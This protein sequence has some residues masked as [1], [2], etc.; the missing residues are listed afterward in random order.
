[1]VRKHPSPCTLLSEVLET[2]IL[3]TGETEAAA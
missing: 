1:L 3:V 2:V